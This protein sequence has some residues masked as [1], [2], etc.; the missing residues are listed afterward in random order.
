[1][2][3]NDILSLVIKP[4]HLA[5][6]LEATASSAKAWVS[7]APAAGLVQKINLEGNARALAMKIGLDTS[8]PGGG[9]Q[10]YLTESRNMSVIITQNEDCTI[11]LLFIGA[12]VPVYRSTFFETVIHAT[13]SML[14]NA[15][16]YPEP[17]VA[18]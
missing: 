4:E 6:V 2:G 14:L 16:D 5:T 11:Q 10:T 3:R 9:W 13:R 7:N 1:M 15:H 12:G 8:I 17:V 18:V